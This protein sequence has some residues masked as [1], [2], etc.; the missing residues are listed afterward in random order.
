MDNSHNHTHHDLIEA[1][2]AGRRDAQFDL[3]KLYSRAMYNTALRMVQNAHDAEDILQSIFVEVFTK[4]ETFRYE[5]SIGAWIKRITINKCINF[6]KSRRLTFNELTGQTDRAEETLPE[7][8][9]AYS[10]E[11]INKAIAGLPD[12]YRVVFSL[13]AVEGYDHEE[14]AQILSITEAT[15]KSQYSRAKAKLR[16]MLR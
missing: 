12:G 10:I 15:S 8:E 9:P 2:R 1:C 7:A 4:L 13:Y 11:R 5:S 3:Y 16:E 6:L 14:I